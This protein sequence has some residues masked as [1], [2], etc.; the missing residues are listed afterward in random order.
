MSDL[1]KRLQ[2]M[3]QLQMPELWLDIERRRP[4]L[5][6]EEP[7]PRWR[8]VGIAAAAF[9]IALGSFAILQRTFREG[10][11]PRRPT[12]VA[13]GTVA[14]VRQGP[15]QPEIA[16]VRTDGSGLTLLGPGQNPAWSPD[17][18]QIAFDRSTAHGT[19]V[20]VM[21]ADGSD[22]RRLTR[23][24]D[25][26]DEEPEWSPD[27][28]Q[29]AFTRS[30]S[31]GEPRDVF[32]MSVRGGGVHRLT[33]P[34][35]DDFSPSWSPDGSRIAFIRVPN[36]IVEAAVLPAANFNQVWTMAADGRDQERV[37]EMRG[38][39]W[40]PAWSPDGDI[41]VFDAGGALWLVHPDGSGL[42][43]VPGTKPL[44]AAFAAW[45]P[46][47]GSLLFAGHERGNAEGQVVFE[48]DLATAEQRILL[49][50][51]GGATGPAW[52]PPL[53]EA[54]TV[55]E[56]VEY[57]NPM[58]IPITMR[59]PVDWFARSV[60]QTTVP[61]GTGDKQIGV[62]I[63]N[64][65][66]A[67]PSTDPSTPSPGPLPLDPRLPPDFVTVTILS[68]ELDLAPGPDSSLPLSMDDAEVAPGLAN[69]RFLEAR[70]AGHAI[71]ISVQGGPKASRADLALA[72]AIVATIRPSTDAADKTSAVAD[73]LSP[74]PHPTV[75]GV[76][77]EC[78]V[79]MIRADGVQADGLLRVL[80]SYAPT[81]LPDGFG[82]LKGY[83]GSGIGMENGLGAVWTDAA[84]H[85][86]HLGILP[87]MAG[88]ESPRPP[89]VWTLISDDDCTLAPLYDVHCRTYHA[90][91]SG[92]VLNLTTV[93]LDDEDASRV[94]NGIHL[95]G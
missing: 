15:T 52:R 20:F 6:P 72:D 58:G 38:G 46:D 65:S 11:Q 24:P 51:P 35:S 74:A 75:P 21:A 89:G 36:G 69:I 43:Q 84:C 32:V 49:D 67:M 4:S 61:D 88:E 2:L 7:Q 55:S 30:A 45:S 48:T 31:L 63:S 50:L 73:L 23:N 79:G 57:T 90:Q 9:S 8:R 17:G 70:V 94:V 82:L 13:V 85:Q 3:E 77:K 34:V 22:V 54:T 25:G 27:G 56:L 76:G 47:G 39:A 28:S 81:W 80:G 83:E 62:V 5:Q 92:A 29:I 26:T 93:G 86:I 66:A 19:G 40:R 14:F 37:T 64:A 12:R 68:S 10:D 53:A 42:D 33:A 71:S 1:K 16:I 78:F 91:S 18:A 44:G 87:D 41:I 59:Y 95:S 60:S